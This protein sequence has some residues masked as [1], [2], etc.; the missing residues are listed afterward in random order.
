MKKGKL[1]MVPPRPATS[2]SRLKVPSELYRRC[3]CTR[4]FVAT[5][6]HGAE[7]CPKCQ[8]GERE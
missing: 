1:A 6:L 4:I 8:P 7:L 2:P 5:A 3:S